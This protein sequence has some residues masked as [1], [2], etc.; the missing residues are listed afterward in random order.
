MNERI[1]E[2]AA[3]AQQVFNKL[4]ENYNE[5]FE[6]FAELMVAEF[7]DCVKATAVGYT[8]SGKDAE[9]I[10]VSVDGALGV[11]KE[12]TKRFGVEE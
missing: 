9:T 11:L 3:E 1:R 5:M 4:D 8:K 10:C 7:S 2:L 6:K 12:I